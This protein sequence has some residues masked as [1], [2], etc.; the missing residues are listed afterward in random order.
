MCPKH[1]NQIGWEYLLASQ[2]EQLF[3]KDDH[4]VLVEDAVSIAVESVEAGLEI[5]VPE[6]IIIPILAAHTV[7]KKLL[8]L[9]PI[10]VAR[11]ILV[12]RVP[13]L[14]DALHQDAVDVG[15]LEPVNLLIILL[16][17]LILFVFI[18]HQ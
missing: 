11:V 15:R 16:P 8:G 9:L 13:Q 10:E 12:V 18:N 4:L 17:V 14:V 1:R 7:I 6:L 2:L 3:D 5:G